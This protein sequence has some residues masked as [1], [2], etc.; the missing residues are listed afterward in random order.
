MS[1]PKS[2]R[3]VAQRVAAVVTGRSDAWR[4]HELA[5]AVGCSIAAVRYCLHH[6]ERRGAVRRLDRLLWIA[7]DPHAAARLVTGDAAVAGAS[8]SMM[9]VRTVH[10][11]L[12]ALSPVDDDLCLVERRWS[13]QMGGARYED[14]PNI[15][16][17]PLMRIAPPEVRSIMG[18]AAALCA[19]RLADR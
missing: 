6:L 19:E 8:R 15:R 18:C 9:R 5:A 16:R 2:A 12:R 4:A 14:V 1:E 7:A 17:Q 11:E 13:L 3:R 10:R